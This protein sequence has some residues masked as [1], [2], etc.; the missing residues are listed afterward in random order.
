MGRTEQAR[1]AIPAKSRLDRIEHQIDGRR[2]R[3]G[4]K[5]RRVGRLVL[6]SRGAQSRRRE[7]QVRKR[8]FVDDADVDVGLERQA[9]LTGFAVRRG[10][11]PGP[12][13]DRNQL[14]FRSLR[15]NQSCS[16]G[17]PAGT[18]E[19]RAGT[20]PPAAISAPSISSSPGQPLMHPLVESRA[21]SRFGAN[22]VEGLDAGHAREQIEIGDEQTRQ[23]RQSSPRR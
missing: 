21:E 23:G 1:R 19:T 13:G 11:E 4:G 18:A 22:D 8:T 6:D 7:I 15:M 20:S 12:A 16:G 17:A 5:R 2:R 9:D 14:L 3:L 10:L